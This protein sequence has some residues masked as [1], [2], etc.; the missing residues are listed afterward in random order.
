MA[1]NLKKKKKDGQQVR[2]AVLGGGAINHKLMCVAEKEF[3]SND[4][5]YHC[6]KG[7]FKPLVRARTVALVLLAKVKLTRVQESH[8]YDPTLDGERI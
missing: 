2:T 6:Y 8:H 4:R 3:R 7:R 1:T 5:G